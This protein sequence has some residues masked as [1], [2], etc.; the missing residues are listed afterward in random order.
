M[1]VPRVLTNG[2]LAAAKKQAKKQVKRKYRNSEEHAA[3]MRERSTTLRRRETY[4]A[5]T[6]AEQRK[7]IARNGF[8]SRGDFMNGWDG[9]HTV[10]WYRIFPTP[11][12]RR[13]K[14]N[15]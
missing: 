10:D 12:T 3:L 4:L 14:R 15:A 6:T 7:Q 1:R 5:N 9:I 13:D 8:M 11:E 2:K